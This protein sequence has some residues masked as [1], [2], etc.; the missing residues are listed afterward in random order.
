M[1]DYPRTVLELDDR[2]STDEACR[3]YLAQLRWPDG[4]VCPRC[5]GRGGL[6]REPGPSHLVARVDTKPR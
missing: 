3:D 5:E 6:A 4:F 2:F 1:E